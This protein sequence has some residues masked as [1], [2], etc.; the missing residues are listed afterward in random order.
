MLVAPSLL[1]ADF[2][3]IKTEITK[4]EAAGADLLHIDIMDGHFVPNL[5]VGPDFVKA[6]KNVTS[7]PLDLHLMVTDPENWIQPFYEAGATYITI[8]QEATPHSDRVIDKINELGIKSG[9][10]ICPATPESNLE[11]LLGK[12]DLVLVMSVNP[13]FG[14]QKFIPEQIKKIEALEKIRKEN[15]FSYK[16]E[17][18]GGINDINA[19]KLITAGVDIL[20]AGSFI[21]SEN[22][23]QKAVKSLRG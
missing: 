9:I 22:D 7:L 21:F 15:R 19:K 6:V 12:V 16:I 20:V 14:G 8:H 3:D 5:T 10:S 13:G 4:I 1:A 11:Y 23:Y 17:V 18:D 2:S